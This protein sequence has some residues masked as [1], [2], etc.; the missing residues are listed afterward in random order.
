MAAPAAKR[1]RTHPNYELL[2]HGGVPGRGEHV[3]LAFEAA[4]VAYKDLGNV[5]SRNKEVYQ[6]CDP[7]S[8]GVDGN[9]PVFAPPI[10]RVPGAGKD[11][12]ALV[13]SQTANILLYL[14]PELDLVGDDDSDKFHV[15]QL[16]LTA[17]DWNNEVHD[18]HHPISTG[19][20]YEDQKPEALRK[21][22]AFREERIPKFLGYFQRVLEGNK[23]HGKGKYLV[24][25]KLTYADTT[26]WQVLNGLRYAFPKEM[27]AR[28]KEYSLVFNDFY[29]EVEE[30]NGIKEYLASD[31]RQPYDMG[32]FR[33]YPELDRQ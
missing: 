33:Y 26:L 12:K 32:I 15:H 11:D 25:S 10:L 6:V 5:K 4:G 24:G 17:L 22:K 20:Y 27:E 7:K 8:L 21:T 30:Q 28:I 13:I 1:Q 14:G 18:T 3:R 9:P 16:A 2:Y 29:P 19:D 31:R 23:E